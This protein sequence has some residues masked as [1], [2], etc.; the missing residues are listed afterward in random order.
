MRLGGRLFQQY[1][2]DAFSCIENARLHWIEK[3]QI[4]LRNDVYNNLVD[5]L[6]KGDV[7][8]V[9]NIGKGSILPASFVGSA[10]YMQQNFLDSLAVCRN[11][12]YPTLFLTMTCNPTCDEI[13]QM[14]RF[15]PLSNP[16][17]CP[18]II[19]RVFKLKLDQLYDLIKKNSYFGECIS[20]YMS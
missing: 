11:I 9:S 17:D 12:G 19:A 13:R 7:P 3:N 15:T 10:R 14:M 1:V 18:D 6:S 4:K 8:D 20:G 5:L 2:V 16:E